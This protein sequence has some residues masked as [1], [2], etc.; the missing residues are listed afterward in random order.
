MHKLESFV[1]NEAHKVFWDFDI[2]M[3]HLTP[4]RKPNLVWINK[5]M[6]I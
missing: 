1:K 2:Q 3:G 4:T 5:K 6:A